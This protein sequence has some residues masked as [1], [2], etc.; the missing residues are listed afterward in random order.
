VVGI[1]GA[2]GN[3]LKQ[4]LQSMDA[5]LVVHQF[6]EILSFGDVKGIWLESASQDALGQNYYGNLTQ[7]RYPAYLICHGGVS[8]SSPTRSYVMDTYGFDLK[9]QGFDRRAEYLKALFEVFEKDPVL[10]EKC[11]DEF[12]GS[13]NPLSGYMW[14][15]G[16][17]PY[18]TIAIGGKSASEPIKNEGGKQEAKEGSKAQEAFQKGL[19]NI[20]KQR[21]KN[22]LK[23]SA[24]CD[25]ILFLASLGGGTGTGFINPITSFVRSEEVIFPIFALGIMTEKGTDKRHAAEG[26]RYLG[27]VIA[28]YDM[29]TKESGKG[30]DGLLLID[31]QILKD[32]F[33]GNYS[34]MDGHIYQALKPLLDLRNYPGDQLQDDA[35]AIRRVFWEVDAENGQDK[36]DR[37]SEIRLLPPM[38]VPCYNIQPDY[39]GDINTLV[40]GAL[41]KSGSLFPLGKDGRLFPCDPV[42]ADRAM[43]F[44]RGFFST[45]EITEAV[46]SRTHLPQSKIKIYRKLGDSR[47]EDVLI[48]LR[49]P[50]GGSPDQ[51]LRQGTLEWKLHEIISLAINYV[52]ENQTNILGFQSFTDL[53]KDRLRKYFYGENGLLDELHN[54]LDRLESGERPVFQR[55]LSIFGDGGIGSIAM[56]EGCTVD[57]GLI[58]GDKAKMRELVK[59]E[60]KE[61]LRS[62]DCRRRIKEIMQ[63]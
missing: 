2:G 1:G 48:L 20:Q 4:F 34:A 40:E 32:M 57:Q 60:L 23:S 29:L 44:T 56:D 26:Q 6:G 19:S 8:D 63:S 11:I 52:D 36:K 43:V 13:D 38:F 22:G 62:E 15:A 59:A 10:K 33:S 58:A 7:N 39:I 53:T 12:N 18:T 27:A 16:I 14:K 21:K 24:Y 55:P 46:A 47:N 54:C 28:M 41:G 25:S 49:N 50:Y 61:I 3:I 17:R 45:A 35:P 5:N 51:H 9:A 30:I 42:K 31:N 37:A